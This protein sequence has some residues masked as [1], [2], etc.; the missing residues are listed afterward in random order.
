MRVS[1]I[2]TEDLKMK[3][4]GREVIMGNQLFDPITYIPSHAEGDITHEDVVGGVLMGVAGNYIRF[5]N[6]QTRTMQRVNPEDLV[7]G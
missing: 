7:W 3:I 4:E 6:C 1:F 5:L 2:T